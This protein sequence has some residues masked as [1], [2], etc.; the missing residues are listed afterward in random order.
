MFTRYLVQCI[1]NCLGTS[2]HTI[3][4][5]IVVWAVVQKSLYLSPDTGTEFTG[6]TDLV[7]IWNVDLVDFIENL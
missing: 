5:R 4:S 1:E 6:S 2:T 3:F 7:G